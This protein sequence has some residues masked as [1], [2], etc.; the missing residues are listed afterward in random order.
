MLFCRALLIYSQTALQMYCRNYKQ[1][2]LEHSYGLLRRAYRLDQALELPE[3]GP[4]KMPAPDDQC[5][6]CKSEYSPIFW[7]TDDGLLDNQGKRRLLCH[8][9]HRSAIGQDQLTAP[10]A[11]AADPSLNQGLSREVS[12]AI[13]SDIDSVD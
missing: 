8:R 2:P 3:A 11:T 13:V 9:C 6:Q 7:P 12:M 4:L 5:Y 10:V 1:V